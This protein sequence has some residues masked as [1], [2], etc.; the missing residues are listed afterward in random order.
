MLEVTH[1]K[2]NEKESPPAQVLVIWSTSATFDVKESKSKEV[3][4][5]SYEENGKT[6]VTLT[7]LHSMWHV[8]YYFKVQYK[9]TT[10]S[11][12]SAK[13]EATTPPAI[14]TSRVQA[15]R[16][17]RETSTAA[18]FQQAFL[19]GRRERELAARNARSFFASLQP[20]KQ[21]GCCPLFLPGMYLETV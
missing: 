10:L 21:T 8:Q 18:R 3:E 14:Q 16:Q 17:R 19:S 2:Q 11:L 7:T 6:V 12:A 5:A 4:L 15:V 9:D 13:M 1:P 20:T